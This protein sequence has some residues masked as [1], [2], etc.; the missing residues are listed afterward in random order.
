MQSLYSPNC[1]STS[2]TNARE[3]Y[4]Y[5]L[6]FHDKNKNIFFALFMPKGGTF[7]KECQKVIFNSFVM[8]QFSYFDQLFF[9]AKKQH[10]LSKN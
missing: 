6:L 5:Y 8:M 9:P 1:N 2:Q 7:K 3:E 10:F 4:K